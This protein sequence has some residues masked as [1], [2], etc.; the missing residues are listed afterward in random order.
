MDLIKLPQEVAQD[1]DLVQQPP[2][3]TLYFGSEV[4]QV[5]FSKIT[6][7]QAVKLVKIGSP[8]LKAKAAKE[9]TVVAKPK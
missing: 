9:E 5:N 7:S 2:Q 6:R 8:Y 1:F 4:G 3:D